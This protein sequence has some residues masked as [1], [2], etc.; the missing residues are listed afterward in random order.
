MTVLQRS[1]E[2]YLNSPRPTIL[3]LPDPAGDAFAHQ[4]ERLARQSRTH[5]NALL[6]IIATLVLTSAAVALVT[7]SRGS[8]SGAAVITALSN[9]LAAGPLLLYRGVW[10][11]SQRA[12]F[13]HSAAAV[14]RTTHPQEFVLLVRAMYERWYRGG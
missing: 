4:V 10:R 6:A 1:I 9:L 7:V 3:G 2:E 11:D 13:L 12:A 8:D 5:A 14:L